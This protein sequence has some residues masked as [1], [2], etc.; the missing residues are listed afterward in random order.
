MEDLRGK[1]L[2]QYLKNSKSKEAK[3]ALKSTM[4]SQFDV[5]Q[6]FKGNF[7]AGKYWRK[8]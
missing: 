8:T 3:A 2:T 6:D 4:L 7:D 5:T 1:V